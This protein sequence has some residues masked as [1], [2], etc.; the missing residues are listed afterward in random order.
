[1][2]LSVLDFTRKELNILGSRNNAGLFA[3]AVET[4]RRSPARVAQLI[5][6]R[7]AFEDAPRAMELLRDHPEKA[8]KVMV[9]LSDQAGP[10]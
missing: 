3:G 4:V 1:M 2:S 10:A 5:T 7:F 9:T 8:E 6:H